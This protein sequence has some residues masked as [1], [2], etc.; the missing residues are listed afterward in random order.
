MGEPTGQRTPDVQNPTDRAAL[1]LEHLG[2][3]HPPEGPTASDEPQIRAGVD[4]RPI[5]PH[6]SKRGASAA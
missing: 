2:A 4:R 6:S 1:R 3:E 5:R